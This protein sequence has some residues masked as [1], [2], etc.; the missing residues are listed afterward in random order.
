MRTVDDGD[1]LSEWGGARAR[2]AMA[3]A[4][5]AGV[6]RS[7][8]ASCP[9]CPINYP[10]W[11]LGHLSTCHL[12]TCPSLAPA[13]SLPWPRPCPSPRPPGS[14]VATTTTNSAPAS[15]WRTRWVLLIVLA[16]RHT[17]I[18]TAALQALPL[19]LL[20]AIIPFSRCP[21]TAPLT[22]LHPPRP[23]PVSHTASAPPP[24]SRTHR[25]PQLAFYMSYHSNKTNQLIHF[26]FIPQILW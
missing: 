2:P 15:T 8:L 26:V 19:P 24:P 10:S 22:S 20:V 4:A 17:G 9:R 18:A 6:L 12:P 5:L 13:H 3:A 1:E 14:P 23:P 7:R 21:A 16:A 11:I 25:S